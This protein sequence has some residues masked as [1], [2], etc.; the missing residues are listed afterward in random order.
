M[1]TA[2]ID[3]VSDARSK[4]WMKRIQEAD[5]VYL[6]S[7]G[8][9]YVRLSEREKGRL[10]RTNSDLLAACVKAEKFIDAIMSFYGEGLDVVNW[11]KNGDPEPL[12]NII[13]S[14]SDGSELES[15]RSA[16]AA[17][18]GRTTPAGA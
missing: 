17:A 16:I 10:S 14:N 2:S 8:E 13:E 7:A 6:G 4:V 3:A 1:D 12:D 11:H 9:M 5:G 18:E 15:L